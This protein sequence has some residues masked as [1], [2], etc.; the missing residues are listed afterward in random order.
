M[1][2]INHYHYQKYIKGIRRYSDDIYD[3]TIVINGNNIGHRLK[4]NRALMFEE[5]VIILLQQ[6]TS[7]RNATFEIYQST[8]Y[9]SDVLLVIKED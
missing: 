2:T 5:M 1:L 8:L 9:T 3:L 6:F 7:Y 4:M